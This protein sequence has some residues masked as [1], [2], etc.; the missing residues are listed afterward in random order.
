[1]R[2]ASRLLLPALLLWGAATAAAQA[3]DS[4][5][6]RAFESRYARAVEKA[7][8]VSVSIKVDRLLDTARVPDRR[9]G[10]FFTG[11][12]FAKRPDGPV[13]GTIVEADGWIATTYFNVQ[14]DLKSVE[15]TLPD[16]AI[17]PAKVMGWDAGADMALLKIEAT[18]LP[19]LPPA[20]SAELRTGDLV[21]AVGRDPE[22]RGVTGNQGILSAGGRHKGRTVQLDARLN[23]G[24]VGG[25]LVDLEGRLVGMTCKVTVSQAGNMGQNS[26]VSFALLSSKIAEILPDLKKGKRIEGGG[27]PFMGVGPDPAYEGKEGAKIGHVVEGGSAKKAGLQIGDIITSLD[28]VKIASFDELRGEILK[29]KIGDTVKVRIVRDG[30]EQEITMALGENPAD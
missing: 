1:M 20:D 9:A 7:A 18:G 16:G 24:N 23:Y 19:T 28:G 15:V 26:G 11:G 4:S 25:P 6:L 10:S 2:L 8:A 27:R 22:G 13:S 3:D 21:I 14:G 12:V 30:E 5:V 17:H 29:K